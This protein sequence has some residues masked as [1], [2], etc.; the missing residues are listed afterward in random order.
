MKRLAQAFC[1]AIFGP[2]M[3]PAQDVS[4]KLPTAFEAL[5]GPLRQ[6]S[7]TLA[8]S[9]E[10]PDAQ[11]LVATARADYRR[12]LTALYAAGHY[13]GTISIRIDGREAASIA[14]LDAPNSISQIVLDVAPGPLFTIGRVEIAPVPTDTA[15]SDALKQGAPALSD[16]VRA[17]VRESITAWRNQGHA[18]AR[19]DGQS[20][21]ANHQT[22]QLNVSVSIDP[23]PRLT[24]G[25]LQVSGNTR[26]REDAVRRIAGLPVG[27]QYSPEELDKAARR[28]RRIA[29][30]SSATMIEADDVS[31]NNTL[32][33]TAQI[34]E[35]KSRRLG[36]GLEYST[37]NGLTVSSFWMHRNAFGG[38]ETFRFDGEISGI[39]GS[40]GGIDYALGT[41]LQ[42]PAIY[43]PDT[44]LRVAFNLGREDEPEY[45]LD[46]ANLELNATRVLSDALI[47]NLGIGLLHAREITDTETRRYT[48]FTLP[49][50]LEY[51]KRDDTKNT[52][53]GYY[54]DVDAT[55][56][57][58][59]S[60]DVNGGRLY[61]DAR[62]YRSFG[63]NNQIT[64]AA[65]GQIGS[66]IGASTSDAPADFLFYSGG[67]STV[68]GQSYQSLS[69][70]NA[71]STTGGTSFLGAQLETRFDV[72]ENVG[73]VGFF[74]FGR[75]GDGT[76]PASS[77][78]WHV[79]AG[80]G[81]R[82]NTGIGPLRLD[83]GFPVNEPANLRDLKVYIGIGQA[84]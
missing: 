39:G 68:R 82:Y 6:A 52:K 4:L 80:I 78:D 50:G 76:L 46:A 30:I 44:D 12:L 55:P 28:L 3:L 25:A 8:L 16:A 5:S 53:S 83:L 17:G 24:F 51:D 58:A 41:S 42:I 69:I 33:I 65:R 38:A 81:I 66:V 47:A 45:L 75:V 63:A 22:D 72:T 18:K 71:G 13:G 36:V 26:V 84:F 49:M 27:D 32:P 23:G 79:G 34:S 57:F 1:F 62:V 59:L 48:L 56:F 64:L 15:Q 74:D 21:A 7:L 73:L 54:I 14:P 70:S 40:T 77:D 37:L 11:D 29:A 31:S 35:A 10:N 2:T 43:G 61:G 19:A 20:I 9:T 67:G 60:G